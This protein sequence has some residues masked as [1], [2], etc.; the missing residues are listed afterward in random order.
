MLTLFNNRPVLQAD[1]PA[2]A[3]EPDNPVAPPMPSMRVKSYY[4]DSV[5][6]AIKQALSELGPE[7]VLLNSR[8][9]DPAHRGLGE[10]EVVFGVAPEDVPARLTAAPAAPQPPSATARPAAP[11]PPP[12]PQNLAEELADLKRQLLELRRAQTGPKP[13]PAVDAAQPAARKKP[14]PEPAGSPAPLDG[15]EARLVVAELQSRITIDSTLGA[16][17]SSHAVVVLVGPPGSGKTSTLIKLAIR[18][19]L[20]EGRP[21]R[22][23]SLESRRPGA[24]GPLAGYAEALKIDLRV[25]FSVHELERT[26]RPAKPGEL[27]LVD[28]PGYGTADLSAVAP[29]AELLASLE[30]ADVHLVLPAS[31]DAACLSRV[32]DL[33]EVLSPRKLL[34]TRTDEAV[35]LANVY[36]EA[37][38]TRKPVSFMTFGQRIP[39]DLLPASMSQI[40]ESIFRSSARREAGLLARI[41]TSAESASEYCRA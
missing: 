24:T 3:D 21:V 28:T 33:Y 8:R 27:V 19:G 37:V 17:G 13:D 29:L 15:K 20:E 39:H 35:H 23:V 30:T 22:F 38:R 34:F 7:A 41:L 36:R 2:P 40:V 6:D 14:L 16:P 25:V 4:T 9:S 10:Y 31:M 11:P 1:R 32:V 12:P 5:G 18:Y 26:L